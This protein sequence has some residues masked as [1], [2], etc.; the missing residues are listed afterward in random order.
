M[1]QHHPFGSLISHSFHTG[2]VVGVD[3]KSLTIT[4]LINLPAFVP[5]G[6]LNSHLNLPITLRRLAVLCIVF[7]VSFYLVSSPTWEVM[8]VLAAPQLS[9]PIRVTFA[10][11]SISGFGMPFSYLAYN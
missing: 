8:A 9:K 1:H 5:D 11:K 6:A 4:T 7:S 10:W 3:I 2:S